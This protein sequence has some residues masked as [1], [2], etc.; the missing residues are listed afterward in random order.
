M[1]LADFVIDFLAKKNI[2]KVFTVSGGGSIFLC[3]A[4][5]KTKKLKYISCHHEQAVAF[6][7]E[8]YSRLKNKP[9]AALVTTGPGG[10]NCLTGVACCWIDSVPTMFISGQVYLDQ[11]IKKTK[12]RQI[13]VQEIDIISMV[14]D[15]TK[16]SVLIKEPNEILYHLEKAYYESTNGRPGPVWIDIPADIQNAEID[17]KK[18]KRFNPFK[19][20]KRLNKLDNQIKKI[21]KLLAK[22]KRPVIHIGH[23]GRISNCEKI[24]RKLVDRYKIPFALTW[25]ASDLMESSHP[26]YIGRPGAFA[27]RGSNFIIQNS[28][29][30]ISVGTRLPFMVT[31][32][33]SKDFARKAKI[34][35]VDIDTK[36]LKN[37]RV[38]T[39]HK[40]KADAGYFLNK[41]LK[42][43][44]QK[45][46]LE[47][48]WLDYCRKVRRKYPIVLDNY[49]K[50]K[51]SINSY[52]FID[53]LSELL[54]PK[55][56]VVTDMGLSFV[57]TH[58]AFK[59][60]KGQ[61]V[62]TNSG[63]APM[64]WGLPAAIG[65]Y[66]ASIE[67][68][69]K[70]NIICLTGEGGL[71]MNIQELATV[72]HH[73]MPIKIFIYNNGGYLTIKQTQQLGFKSRIMGSNYDSGL[74]FPNYKLLS[75]SHNIK[76]FKISDT[77]KIKNTISNI[78]KI[79]E[80]VIC[81]LILDSEQEQIPK[82]INKRTSDGKSIPTT[83]EDMYPFLPKNELKSNML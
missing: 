19:T 83:F 21:A 15:F 59:V 33:N 71:Q 51:K 18:L 50:Q 2:K 37:T 82:A 38:L 47:K 12:L 63:H 41:L 42:E 67:S 4:L 16:Y 76:Y 43:L 65:A 10:T 28:D 23:G 61:R 31:G 53:I 27:E 36:E 13:G 70:K 24:L 49:K 55:D 66:Y 25:N 8:S 39:N 58:Q 17:I 9:G 35:M 40:L 46:D 7:A 20:K 54:K 72:L 75:R 69:G 80:P 45:I 14:K 73:K 34:V 64:G 81:E 57:G 6:A 26:S 1:R 74:S 5:F 60:K 11:T 52:Y 79:N 78:L 3:D 22:S 32:Y 56:V 30:Y 44:P 29:L 68:K 62:F 48:N 77:K